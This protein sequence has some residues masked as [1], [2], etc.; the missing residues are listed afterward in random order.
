MCY[1]NHPFVTPS[2]RKEMILSLC[3]F[4]IK[5]GKGETLRQMEQV[6]PAPGRTHALLF[7]STRPG[8]SCGGGQSSSCRGNRLR[9]APAKPRSCRGGDRTTH[10]RG[11]SLARLAPC[12]REATLRCRLWQRSETRGACSCRRDGERHV[13]LM[14]ELRGLRAFG[15][16]SPPPTHSQ[17]RSLH[18]SCWTFQAPNTR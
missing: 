11:R 3:A 4:L 5:K 10:G 7:R 2:R 15:W 1:C 16:A 9:A 8:G 6:F 14:A 12:L 18:G 13:L 17:E